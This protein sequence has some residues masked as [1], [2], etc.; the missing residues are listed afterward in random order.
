[1]KK[2]HY[3]NE[4]MLV[5]LVED[6]APLLR[7]MTFLLEV[8]GFTVI[9]ASNGRQAFQ[10]I[11]R[12]TPDLIISDIDMPAMNGYDLLH[13]VRGHRQWKDVPF[14]FIS[15]KYSYEEFIYGLDL[16][17]NYYVP[18][19]FDLQDLL[20]AIEETLSGPGANRFRDSA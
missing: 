19:P 4:D 9:P 14:I 16:G 6:H 15:D 5:L 13:E 7:N 17:A 18:K 12:Q 20:F 8:S 1:M 2:E 3:A 11:K 10:Q